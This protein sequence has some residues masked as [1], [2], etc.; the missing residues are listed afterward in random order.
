MIAAAD[1]EREC[2]SH[3]LAATV[4]MRR[5][6]RLGHETLGTVALGPHVLNLRL[7]SHDPHRV[8]DTLPIQLDLRRAVWFDVESG[9]VIR[10]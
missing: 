9:A 3:A 6:D 2:P 7:A 1:N 8:G 5:L 10:D 4:E